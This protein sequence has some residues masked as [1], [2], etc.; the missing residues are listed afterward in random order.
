MVVDADPKLTSLA[1]EIWRDS[2]DVYDDKL[3]EHLLIGFNPVLASTGALAGLDM[4]GSF[5][6]IPGSAPAP[7][8]VGLM[9]AA[10]GATGVA[11]ALKAVTGSFR[12]ITESFR[13]IGQEPAEPPVTLRRVF[14]LPGKL[15][16]VCLPPA[17]EL[18]AMA[19][20]APVMAKLEVF[21]RWLGE[22]GRPVARTG[23]L[24][25][26]DAADAARQVGIGPVP[27]MLLWEYALTSGWFE[28][29]GQAG[30]H[31]TRAVIGETARRW[32]DVDDE[33]AL[34]VW[35]VVFAAMATEALDT[36]TA[37]APGRAGALDFRG[38]GASLAVRL[39]LS[40]R[41][42]MTTRDAENLVRDGAV[43]E[44]PARRSKRAW[45]AWSRQYG[46]PAHRLLGE[47]AALRAVTLPR[48]STETIEL[49][50]LA[51]WALREQFMLDQISVPVLP[52]PSPRM[53]GANLLALADTVGEAKFDAAFGTWMAHRDPDRAVRELLIYAGS[54]D[55]HGRLL[56]VDV[57][58]RIG[59]PGYRAWK[60]AMRRP[61][62]RGYARTSLS[63]MAARLP[64][65]T[66][67]LALEPD[68]EDMAWVATD[69]LATACGADSPDPD[70]VAARFAEAMPAGAE[71]WFFAQMAQ[72]PHPDVARVLQVLSI[73]H[74]D[75]SVA[76]N[77]RKAM[78]AVAKKRRVS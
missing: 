13:V 36:L 53:S 68:P 42:G 2:I 29:D 33:G 73:Y 60:D 41:H 71:M 10:G 74:P 3:N 16:G 21:A 20:T 19:R 56:A 14:K 46:D 63:T 5:R 62:L 78:R 37:A 55:A 52:P 4:T 40:R 25:G 65:S 11:G 67:P 58:R 8:D 70:E 43:G 26:T 27:L 38:Q 72:S 17:S 31:G 6:R 24:T 47:L 34:H 57:A 1:A 45:D 15:P 12:V 75:R 61:E 18:A 77:A 51:L 48:T 69:L 22:N 50:P 76:R 66:L 30:E 64:R 59:L 28:L 44:R 32:T 7:A 54:A 9:S 49:T 35:A 39:F 23:D